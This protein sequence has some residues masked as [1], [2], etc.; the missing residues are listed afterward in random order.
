M[1]TKQSKM[2]PLKLTVKGSEMPAQW[3]KQAGVSADEQVEIVIRPD[4]KAAAE[5][6]LESMRRMRKQAKERGL[7]PEKLDSLLET[8]RSLSDFRAQVRVK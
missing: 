5:Q 6:V 8:F 3:A 4:H 1:G 2:S 7:T